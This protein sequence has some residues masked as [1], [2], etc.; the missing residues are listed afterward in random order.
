MQHIK[1]RGT[2]RRREE[3]QEI[4]KKLG[5]LPFFAVKNQLP[6]DLKNILR[7]AANNLTHRGKSL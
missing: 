1:E 5:E 7:M 3:H 6:M 4:H 2:G